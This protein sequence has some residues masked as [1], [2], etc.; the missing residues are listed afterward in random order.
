MG[1][2]WGAPADFL[3]WTR[4]LL[5]HATP[6]RCNL[7]APRIGEGKGHPCCTTERSRID[8]ARIAAAARTDAQTRRLG[9]IL[10]L[11]RAPEKRTRTDENAVS[12]SVHTCCTAEEKERP[13]VSLQA[14]PSKNCSMSRLYMSR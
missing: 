12:L 11:I 2:S 10:L 4:A 5:V 9:H 13:L 1:Q 8:T 3:R 7:H 14:A 6:T